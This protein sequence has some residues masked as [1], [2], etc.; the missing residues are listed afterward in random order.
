MLIIFSSFSI[1]EHRPTLL[2]LLAILSI[3]YLAQ[4]SLPLFQ[5]HAEQSSMWFLQA[6]L[7]ELVA[8]IWDKN[9]LPNHKPMNKQWNVDMNI[10]L[11]VVCFT[12]MFP[13]PVHSVRKLTICIH[14]LQHS[15]SAWV[16]LFADVSVAP[17]N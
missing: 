4:I 16:L 12:D 6:K 14:F 3:V 2:N 13:L 7:L 11:N 17:P 5:D 9:V 10:E 15:I 8:D 1:C